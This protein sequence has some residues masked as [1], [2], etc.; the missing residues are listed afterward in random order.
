MPKYFLTLLA[1]VLGGGAIAG[2]CSHTPAYGLISGVLSLLMACAAAAEWE[3]HFKQQA[4][5][6][7]A[8]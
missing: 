3:A 6:R 4:W 5:L 1:L 2:V 8:Y 7:G